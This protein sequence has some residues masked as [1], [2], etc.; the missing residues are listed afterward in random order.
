MPVIWNTYVTDGK[1]GKD[2]K[3]A[4]SYKTSYVFTR[5]INTPN[6]P[7]GGKFE[8]GLPTNVDVW[9]DTVPASGDGEV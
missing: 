2:G 1:D 7:E 9:S 8:T 5:S 3:D 4:V 6:N